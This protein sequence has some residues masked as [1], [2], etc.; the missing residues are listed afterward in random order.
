[1][2]DNDR[3]PISFYDIMTKWPDGDKEAPTNGLKWVTDLRAIYIIEIGVLKC[4]KKWIDE[5]TSFETKDL[6]IWIFAFSEIDN[7]LKLTFK[8][9]FLS[10]LT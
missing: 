9:K 10:S 1:M 6:E 8:S 7:K 2:A 3:W 4:K 5:N